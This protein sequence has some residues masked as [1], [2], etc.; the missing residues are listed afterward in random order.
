M[1]SLTYWLAAAICLAGCRAPTPT[2]KDV[3]PFGATR[4]EPPRTHSFGTSDSYYQPPGT[5][6]VGDAASDF[7]DEPLVTVPAGL[8][9]HGAVAQVGHDAEL[10]DPSVARAHFEEGDSYPD[11]FDDDDDLA[12]GGATS[13]G[14][15]ASNQEAPASP[16]TYQPG[17]VAT[18]RY[19]D[20]VAYGSVP[21]P[22]VL[23][24]LDASPLPG[25][26]TE[27]LSTG[28]SSPA[29]RTLAA[30]TS[31]IDS[32]TGSEIRLNPMAVNDVTQFTSQAAS[33]EAHDITELPAVPAHVRD[34]LERERA[35]STPANSGGILSASAPEHDRVLTTSATSSAGPSSG[36]GGW[37]VR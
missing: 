37:R 26:A 16:R 10:E 25:E 13:S 24:I 22:A 20:D 11:R 9:R 5:A 3:S 33:G 14:R 28:S 15:L 29:P 34:R 36:A 8:R 4:I 1:K 30:N 12:W 19:D 17:S 32:T 31:R 6:K 27:E 2:F 23:R 35:A 21:E 7:D 18:A